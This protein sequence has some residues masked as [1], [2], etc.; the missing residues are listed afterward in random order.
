MMRA[1]TLFLLTFA[2]L[3]TT[4]EARQ[5]R[6]NVEKICTEDLPCN[7]G[8]LVWAFDLQQMPDNWRMTDDPDVGEDRFF[9]RI[10][11]TGDLTGTLFLISSVARDGGEQA[12][13][14]SILP[15]NRLVMSWHTTFENASAET[16]FGTCD[17]IFE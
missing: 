1:L 13:L 6:C 12:T 2:A 4:A 5:F 16:A 17:E 9:D 8:D 14:L 15:D 7:A 3:G 10:A 11:G